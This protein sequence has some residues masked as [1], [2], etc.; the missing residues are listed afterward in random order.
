MNN[1]ALF[2]DRDGT[3]VQARHY[4]S[5]PE[6][7]ILF[8]SIGEPLA[9]LQAT[10][11]LLIVITNQSGLAHG[12]FDETALQRMNAHLHAELEKL[13]VRLDA[14]YYCPHHP[15]GS[16]A[17]YAIECNCRK[18]RPG[19]LER[20]AR[21]L[22]IDL[23]RS[24]FVGDILHDVE[25]GNRAGCRTVLVN[26]GGETEWIAGPYRTPT[27]TVLSTA[28]AFTKIAAEERLANPAVNS[29]LRIASEIG[30]GL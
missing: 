27:F 30:V 17:T 26:N 7:L 16:V 23:K 9:L 3:L 15:D 4:P 18:P 10:G 21:D 22:Q 13:G 5:R 24:W 25:A 2:V 14:V 1:R 6:D 20:A 8:E 12:Y 29:Q 11:F 28:E 19:L